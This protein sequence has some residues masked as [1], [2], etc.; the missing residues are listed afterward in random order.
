MPPSRWS[1][2]PRDQCQSLG[3]T[4]AARMSSNVIVMIDSWNENGVC[5][6]RR[7]RVAMWSAMYIPHRSLVQ[8]REGVLDFSGWFLGHLTERVGESARCAVRSRAA[9]GRVSW[10][11][12]EWGRWNVLTI[13]WQSVT[14]SPSNWRERRRVSAAVTAINSIRRAEPPAAGLIGLVVK[15]MGRMLWFLILRCSIFLSNIIIYCRRQIEELDWLGRLY[16]Y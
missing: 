9:P 2:E 16:S 6:G 10:C 1:C 15:W 4:A 8:A 13:L 12:T 5:W 14:T 7:P 3:C 11:C